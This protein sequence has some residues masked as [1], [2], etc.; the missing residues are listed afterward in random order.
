MIKA[1]II[2]SAKEIYIHRKGNTSENGTIAKDIIFIVCSR[3]NLEISTYPKA[4]GRL[5]MFAIPKSYIH[6]VASMLALD[7]CIIS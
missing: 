5:R 4:I 6:T 2:K 1:I 7:T 3:R